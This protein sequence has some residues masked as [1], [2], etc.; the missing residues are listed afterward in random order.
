MGFFQAI[1]LEWIAIS[2]SRGS[3]Q[4]RA[5]TW[6]SRI[7]DRH[8]TIWATKSLVDFK[9]WLDLPPT[10]EAALYYDTVS[11]VT[12]CTCRV[13]SWHVICTHSRVAIA[14]DVCVLMGL[15]GRFL[16]KSLLWVNCVPTHQTEYYTH[17]IIVGVKETP[18]GHQFNSLPSAGAP[19]F[20]TAPPH[21]CP[22]S[23]VCPLP[24]MGSPL[25]VKYS[26]CGLLLL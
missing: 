7:V 5:Q 24:G 3:S 15:P 1:V 9:S 19:S 14:L 2:F 16:K 23:P 8:F 20:P 12:T 21:E 6:V 25:W 18:R 22:L 10:S 11:C 4:P 26:I 13:T 17:K